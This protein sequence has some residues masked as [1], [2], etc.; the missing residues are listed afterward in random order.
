MYLDDTIAA[1]ATAPGQGGVGVIRVS[2]PACISI[3]SQVF[4]G[5]HPV[6][7][8]A[9]H[10]LYVGTI[11]TPTGTT[12]DRGLAVIMRAP[13]S[14]TGEDVA[15]LHCHGSP[16]LLHRI[17]HS[18]LACGARIAEPGEFTKRSFLNGKLDLSQAE[19]VID[20][21]TARTHQ[22]ADLAIRQL[23]GA[24]SQWVNNLREGA[25]RLKAL[26]EA[27]IDFSEEDFT[28]D[29]AEMLR[30]L[31]QCE[32]PLVALLTTYERGKLIRD[33]LRVAIVGRPNVGKSSLLNALLGEERAIVTS[34]AGTTRDVIEECINLDGVPVVIADTAGLRGHHQADTVERLGMERTLKRIQGADLVLVVIDA[35]Q[36]LA[37]EDTEVLEITAATPRLIV[38]NKSD[39]PPRITGGRFSQDR[40][41]AVS[42]T[43]SSSLDD[44]RNA[45]IEVTRDH[46]PSPDT[47]IIT[48]ARHHAA[49]VLA[50]QS[51]DLASRSISEGR[52]CDLIAV[53]LQDALDHLGSITGIVTNED[54]LDRIFSEF[55]V[56]K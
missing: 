20:A 23:S 45:L 8:W 43:D 12:L 16:V 6:P 19:A 9:S 40:W 2:G 56:G 25:I 11:S 14:Y 27:Q 28:V 31:Q 38:L 13:R 7:S 30:Q 5:A 52:S 44:L 24:V 34:V 36:P 32:Q 10:H 35:S 47:P 54:V 15:E 29:Q 39:L 26:V 41:V 53:D 37:D 3:L 4:E 46:P 17:L 22:G 18:V 1:I 50:A 48:R 42:A 49:L 51:L 33:G 55:C 21:V